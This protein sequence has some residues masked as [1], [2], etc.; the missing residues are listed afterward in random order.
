VRALTSRRTR[1]WVAIGIAG[2]LFL[3]V[4]Y[5]FYDRQ[6]RVDQI[7]A[8]SSAL[9]AQRAQAQR[10]GQTPVAPPPKQ[11]LATPTQ[12]AGPPGDRGDTG[13]TGA[14]GAAGRGLAS[15][16]C[17]SG[18]WR[19]QYTDGTVDNSAGPCTGPPGPI[20]AAGGVGAT[21]STGPAGKNGQDGAA[22]SSGAQGD[23][24]PTGPAGP[25]GSAGA[26]G[27][28]GKDGANG[29][30]PASW[31]WNNALGVTYRCTRDADSPDSAPT[32]A[33]GPVS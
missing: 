2:L 17:V 9:N 4:A 20:G 28:A 8:L 24:G 15:V 25:A 13:A 5:L 27:T 1:D 6:T 19:V 31:T 29:Q 32:Y 14:T 16:I 33:C 22:G 12:V 11:I 30:P 10:A 18:V 21:G 7:N 26:D 3:A 23:P